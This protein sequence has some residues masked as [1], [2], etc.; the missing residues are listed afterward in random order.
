MLLLL[1]ALLG[2]TPKTVDD[3]ANVKVNDAPAIQKAALPRIETRLAAVAPMPVAPTHTDPLPEGAAV[4][5]HCGLRAQV[6]VPTPASARA[7]PAAPA[8]MPS[9]VRGAPASASDDATN[10]APVNKPTNATPPPAADLPAVTG[11]PAKG[12]EAT[13]GSPAEASADPAPTAGANPPG[14][15]VGGDISAGSTSTLD[16]HTKRDQDLKTDKKKEAKNEPLAVTE[17]RTVLEED[18]EKEALHKDNSWLEWGA[19]VHLSNDDSMSLASAQRLLWN[20]MNGQRPDLSQIRPHELLNYFSFDTAAVPE[21]QLFSVL[22]A[23]EQ[24]GDGISLALAVKGGTPERQPL[25]LTV[26]VDT[27]GS[28]AAEGRMA[29]TQRGL[30]QMR[31]QLR[32][33]D[34]V[35]LVMFSGRVCTPLSNFVVGRDDASLLNQA[36]D[37]LHPMGST[38]LDRGLRTAYGLQTAR[39]ADDTHG[40]NRRVMLITDAFLN[41]GSVQPELVTEIGRHYEDAGIRLT[42]IGV[43]REFNDE[44]LDKL[45]EKGKGAYIYLGSEAVVDRVFGVGFGSLTQTIAHDVRFSLD[46]PPS[47]AMERFYGEESS[48]VESDIQ[49]IHYYANTSQVFLQD[50]AIRDG[51]IEANDPVTMRIKWRDAQTGEPDELELRTTIGALLDGDARNLHKAQSL[52]AWADWS[53]TWAMQG[54]ACGVALDT[55]AIARAK[56][57]DD[58]ELD[59]VVGLTEQVCRRKAIPP[60]EVAYKVNV[61]SDVPIAEVS[62][63]CTN[64]QWVQSLSGGDTVARFA[65]ARPGACTLTLQGPVAMR[66]PVEVPEVDGAVRCLVR[67]GRVHCG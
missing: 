18:A 2:C 33:G 11:A 20:V 36:I 47:L 14:G 64:G 30:R 28:M 40:R 41:T 12:S 1:L 32:A 52:M 10:A 17:A 43:G 50:L 42:G 58:A 15:V 49:P 38:D 63:S 23:A 29:Y 25:D 55:F 54:H 3:D 37:Q 21:G 61:D 56:V 13:T 67:G 35:D 6:P 8:P 34:R 59:F 31:D 65:D 45:T 4:Y 27:S 24:Q 22:G 46:L 19:T 7:H 66:A 44:V 26:V 9:P 5:T 16:R 60:V 48:T 62:L 39:S 53:Q 57:G 51:G